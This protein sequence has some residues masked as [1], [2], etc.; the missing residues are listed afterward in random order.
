[1]A[2]FN[3]EVECMVLLWSTRFETLASNR[4]FFCTG[5]ERSNCRA[6]Q[7]AAFRSWL[8]HDRYRLA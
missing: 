7:G 6:Y 4:R 2:D 1:M 3:H 8:S 5:R